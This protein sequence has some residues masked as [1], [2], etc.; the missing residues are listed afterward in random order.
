MV[1]TVI[2]FCVLVKIFLSR[3]VVSLADARYKATIRSVRSFCSVDGASSMIGSTMSKIGGRFTLDAS[4][5]MGSK[6]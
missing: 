2:G 3:K 4:E 6:A 1:T 5:I